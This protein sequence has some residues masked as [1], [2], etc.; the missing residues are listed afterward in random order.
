MTVF[1]VG[2]SADFLK[3]NGQPAFPMF[4]LSPLVNAPGIELAYVPV[5]DSRI[6]AADIKGY[7]ALILLGARFD[8][9]SH[10]G[11]GRL[12]LIARF[13]VGYDTVD[14][15]ACTANEVALVITPDGVRRPVA[16]AILSMML[17]LSSKLLLKDRLAR[18]GSTGWAQRADYMGDGLIGRTLGSIGLGNIGAELFRMAQPLQMRF[19]ACDPY[20]D[21]SVAKELGI[22]LVDL[23]N[24]F[25]QSDFLAVNCPFSPETDKLVNAERL[26]LMKPSAYLINTARGP[27]VDETALVDALVSGKIAGAALDV[28]EVEPSGADNPLFQLDNVI[29]SP[30]ALSWTDQC[31]SGIGVDDVAAALAVS[32]GE[33]PVG[34]VNKEILE[35]PGWLNKLSNFAG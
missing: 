7:D 15:D 27:I 23:T 14:V 21:K 32:K 35:S 28:F 3:P 2:L 5:T 4:D 25:R 30:H 24:L 18:Q 11:D 9:D 26:A 20:A 1:K 33:I 10:P 17:A 29:V 8:A 34:I 13:G 19:I 31:F 6:Q 22:E 12:A 16:V